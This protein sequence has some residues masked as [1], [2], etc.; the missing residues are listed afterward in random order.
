MSTSSLDELANCWARIAEE[1]AF[2]VEYDGVASAE[3]YRANA[4]PV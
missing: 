1:T 4:M 3:A 2:P